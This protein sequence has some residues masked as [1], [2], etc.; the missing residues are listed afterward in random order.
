MT[1]EKKKKIREKRG[2]INM[3]EVLENNQNKLMHTQKIRIKFERG[4]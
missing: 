1:L 4:D 2:A 3:V